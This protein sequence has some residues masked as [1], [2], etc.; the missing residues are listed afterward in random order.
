MSDRRRGA[1][2]DGGDESDDPEAEDAGLCLRPGM[3]SPFHS[4][5]GSRVV[6]SY[7]PDSRVAVGVSQIPPQPP[8]PP[9]NPHLSLTFPI[10]CFFLAEKHC[11][12]S[13]ATVRRVAIPVSGPPSFQG[14][15]APSPRT[16]RSARRCR[17]GPQRP[18]APSSAPWPASSAGPPPPPPSPSPPCSST[19]PAAGT[20]AQP[21]AL[22]PNPRWG[23]ATR[24]GCSDKVANSKIRARGFVT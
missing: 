11:L 21:A 10:D 15:P 9:V 20:S 8:L 1:T 4:V 7:G 23:C 18:G 13:D 3:P 24:G 6:S 16:C 22:L 19:A 14:P 17:R 12:V 2:A 5:N